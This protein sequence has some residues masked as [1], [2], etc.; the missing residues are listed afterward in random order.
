MKGGKLIALGGGR[1]YILELGFETCIS[2]QALTKKLL[3]IGMQSRHLIKCGP[4][5]NQWYT[6]QSQNHASSCKLPM[7]VIESRVIISTLTKNGIRPDWCQE[8]I[9]VKCLRQSAYG[10][11]H[12]IEGCTSICSNLS[13]TYQ[14]QISNAFTLLGKKT[15]RPKLYLQPARLIPPSQMNVEK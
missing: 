3:I 1:F 14:Q 15:H 4:G 10:L 11:S 2:V 9:Q 7:A 6:K 5:H 8:Q 12:L 13:C